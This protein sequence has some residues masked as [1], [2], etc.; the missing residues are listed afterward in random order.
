MCVWGN[1]KNVACEGSE[2]TT[3]DVGIQSS[4]VSRNVT[5]FGRRTSIR[6]EPEMW[7]ALNDISVREKCSV[8]DICSLVCI[9]KREETSLTAAIRVFLMLYYRSA[10]TEQG[11]ARAGHGSFDDMKLRARIPEDFEKFFKRGTRKKIIHKEQNDNVK[12]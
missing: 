2:S 3:S 7:A 1:M 11:H 8:H 5:I 10:S 12:K 6:L 9:R 4:L